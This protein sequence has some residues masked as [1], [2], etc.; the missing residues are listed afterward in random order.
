M[1]P[2][3]LLAVAAVWAA[4]IIPPLL[5]S[6][7]ENRPNSSVSDFRRQ[8][9][10]LQRAVPTR[11]M[12]PMRGMGRP[13][14]QAPQQRQMSGQ[15]RR[16]PNEQQARQDMHEGSLRGTR[17]D[18]STRSH[19]TAH[20]HKVSQREVTRRRRANVVF[21][22]VL[23]VGISGFLAATTHSSG[24]VYIFALSFISLC[25]YCYKLVQIRNYEMDRSYSD[26]TWFNAA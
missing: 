8:L 16:S 5:R 17:N 3:V 13:L 26:H 14:T 25:G 6:R 21:M 2:V 23:T 9:S 1:Q 24:L 18:D 19:R 20:L 11:T 15:V 7:V 4:V 22:L 12:V 10:T